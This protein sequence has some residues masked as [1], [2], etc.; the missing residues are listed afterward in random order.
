MLNSHCAA[1]TG[2]DTRWQHLLAINPQ[3]PL[4]GTSFYYRLF[5]NQPSL[6]LKHLYLPARDGNKSPA[7]AISLPQA[8]YKLFNQFYQCVGNWKSVLS[9]E[10]SCKGPGSKCKSGPVLM[11]LQRIKT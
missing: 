9:Y 4:K 7:D 2:S 11:E 3:E 5:P 1:V 8:V 6:A 10:G